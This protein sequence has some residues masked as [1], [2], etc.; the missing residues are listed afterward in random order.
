MLYIY[1]ENK[2]AVSSTEIIL[3]SL[4]FNLNESKLN[5]SNMFYYITYYIDSTT[6]Q[7]IPRVWQTRWNDI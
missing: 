7:S 1:L 6:D 3:F 2:T 5:N 4:V